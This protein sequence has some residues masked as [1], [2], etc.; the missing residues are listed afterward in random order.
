MRMVDLILAKRNGR[1]HSR[2]EIDF[3]IN[4]VTDG[5]IKDYQLSAWLMA[6]CWLLKR[7]LWRNKLSESA[8]NA[9]FGM[10]G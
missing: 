7:W 4:G 6:V 8:C 5:S 2:S 1:E 9:D 10:K 3:I